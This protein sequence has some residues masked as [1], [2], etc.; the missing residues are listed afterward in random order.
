MSYKYRGYAKYPGYAPTSHGFLE[1]RPD[2]VGGYHGGADNAAAPRT[3]VYAQYGGEIFR[4]GL[5]HGYGMAVVVKS[6]APDGTKF[7]Q[8]YGHLGPGPLPAPGTP[9]TADQPIPGAVIGTKEYVQ[10]MG[11]ITSGPHLHREIISGNAP[12]N[13]DGRFGVNSSDITY[14]ADPDTFDINHPV[15]P[16]E[17]HEPKPLPQPGPT[18]SS[19]RSPQIQPSLPGSVPQPGNPQSGPMLQP[20]PGMPIPGAEFPTSIGGPNGP[21]PLV[22]PARSRLQA[23]P[24]LKPPADPTLPPLHFAPDAPQNFGPFAVPG[25]FRPDVLGGSGAASGAAANNA[26]VL[27]PPAFGAPGASA[28]AAS[29]VVPGNAGQIGD[30]NGVGDWWKSIAPPASN[31]NP[32]SVRRLSSPM[33]GIVAVD[34]NSPPRVSDP[35]PAIAGGTPS[36]PSLPP[37]WSLPEALL[38]PDRNRAMDDWTMPLPFRSA[39]PPTQDAPGGIPGLMAQGGLFDPSNPDEPPP[40][41]LLRLIRDWMRNNPDGGSAP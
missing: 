17:N 16:F 25:P 30:G 12:L 32:A 40:G 23:S 21:A 7:Y 24:S 3:P 6:T 19:P 33:L 15:F 35:S 5:I 4:S 22:P 28:P 39:P 27:P 20:S 14:K 10:R 2:S 18:T 31:I 13:P 41:G 9:V 36:L 26:P 37:V 1:S 8:L 34:P 29:P 11:G 38:A